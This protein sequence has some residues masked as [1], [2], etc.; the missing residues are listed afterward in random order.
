MPN[1]SKRRTFEALTYTD[2]YESIVEKH[3]RGRATHR[4]EDTGPYKIEELVADFEKCLLRSRQEF[5]P[6]PSG[7]SSRLKWASMIFQPEEDVFVTIFV[8]GNETP[9]FKVSVSACS[10]KKAAET[11]VQLRREYLPEDDATGPGF[12]IMSDK[13]RAQ[14]ANLERKHQLDSFHLAL[15]YGDNFP[16]W[17]REF[18]HGLSEHGISILRGSPGTGK[19]TYLR[20]VMCSLAATHRFYF[21]P[22]DNFELLTSGRLTAFWKGEHEAHPA[23]IKVL[24]LEDTETLLFERDRDIPSPVSALL[25]ITDGL[26]TQLVKLHLICTLNC[27]MEDLD[28]AI[29]RP[30]RLRFFKE[31]ER[32]PRERAARMADHYSLF[33]PEGSDFTLAELFACPNFAELTAGAVRKVGQIGFNR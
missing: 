20:H 5:V 16:A 11:L 30:G 24:V 23:A 12:F 18:Q 25:N 27:K 8:K 21:V 1:A 3:F 13:R 22:V 10:A 17:D 9:E 4:A 14:R 7:L 28:T 19:T 6:A 31:F 2:S 26:I 29:L 33:L 32:I 15:H